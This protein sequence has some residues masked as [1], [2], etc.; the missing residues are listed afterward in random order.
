M[1]DFDRIRFALFD[2]DYTL[3]VHTEHVWNECIAKRQLVAAAAGKLYEAGTLRVSYDL[4]TF[5]ALCKDHNVRLGLISATG[6]APRVEQKMR[7]VEEHYGVRMQNYCVGS[8]AEKPGAIE[9]IRQAKRF[10]SDEILLVDDYYKALSE[11]SKLGI[12]V[13]SPAEVS[14]FLRDNGYV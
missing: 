6:F 5:V 11:A 3:A 14:I 4:K 2:F 8:V 13:A 10:C 12:Q 7:W 1:I 9:A